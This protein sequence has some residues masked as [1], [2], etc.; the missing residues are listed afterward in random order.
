[1]DP[2]LR[3]CPSYSGNSMRHAGVFLVLLLDSN[4]VS[5]DEEL[6]AEGKLC[7]DVFI[8]VDMMRLYQCKRL[9]NSS[10]P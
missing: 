10:N 4:M 7:I 3:H 2:V 1:M 5:R 9:S 8:F 6:S